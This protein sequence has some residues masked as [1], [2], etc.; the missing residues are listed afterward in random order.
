MTH[1]EESNDFH[2]LPILIFYQCK[3][4]V[5]LESE[6]YS[7]HFVLMTSKACQIPSWQVGR[8]ITG[9]QVTILTQTS[10]V[11]R[12]CCETHDFQLN[13]TVHHE[14]LTNFGKPI[15][16]QRKPTVFLY[17]Q[18]LIGVQKSSQFSHKR[19][20]KL[21]SARGLSP[22]NPYLENLCQIRLSLD[23]SLSHSESLPRNILVQIKMADFD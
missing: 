14:N 13:L 7:K 20:N 2:S 18:K 22:K 23:T 12:F 4:N 10:Q 21:R 17:A 6:M 16:F 1:W 8:G 11:S 5:I 19:T 9:I 3:M 15:V